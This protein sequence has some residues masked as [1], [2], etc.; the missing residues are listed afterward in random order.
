MGYT[1][2]LRLGLQ[3]CSPE[4]KH[5]YTIYYNIHTHIQ[6]NYGTA[7]NGQYISNHRTNQELH[8]I[9]SIKENVEVQVNLP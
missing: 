5:T 6:G 8:K 2:A 9:T 3:A 4:Y 1:K 7:Y